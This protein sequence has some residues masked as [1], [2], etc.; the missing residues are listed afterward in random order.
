MKPNCF[1]IYYYI[2][3]LIFISLVYIAGVKMYNIKTLWTKINNR[4]YELH[5]DSCLLTTFI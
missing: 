5:K 1:C 4:L 3:R 2:L